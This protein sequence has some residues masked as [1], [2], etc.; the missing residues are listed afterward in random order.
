[1]RARRRHCDAMY[2]IG[3]K[4]VSG[5]IS[6]GYP[7]SLIL[8]RQGHF[9]STGGTIDKFTSSQSDSIILLHRIQPFGKSNSILIAY[10]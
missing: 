7:S 1:M 8:E 9:D 6:T 4:T 3:G 5:G 2:L 10:P